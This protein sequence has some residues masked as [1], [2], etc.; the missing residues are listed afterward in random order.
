MPHSSE[1][2]DGLGITVQAGLRES[3]A[4]I[5]SSH[6]SPQ[7]RNSLEG[8]VVTTSSLTPSSSVLSGRTITFDGEEDTAYKGYY[9]QHNNP[10]IS[11]GSF[12]SGR[13]SPNRTPTIH[14]D[15]AE[16]D[17]PAEFAPI[18]IG[19]RERDIKRSLGSWLSIV[20]FTLS[21]FCA[22]FSGIF[23]AIAISSPYWGRR[24][25]SIQGKLSPSAAATLT[26][27][28]AKMVEMAFVTVMVAFIGQILARRATRLEDHGGITLS[29]MT[30]R[31]WIM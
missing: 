30:M 24:V 5:P 26:S 28:F 2:N 29:E 20:A 15:D 19:R 7:L 9:G 14:E 12:G 11:G 8:Q 17:A 31:T 3:P 6:E 21:I 13:Y 18:P 4:R 16:D 27:F 22:V 10:K 23:L 25:S 1:S